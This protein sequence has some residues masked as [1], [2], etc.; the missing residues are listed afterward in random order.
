MKQAK[1]RLESEFRVLIGN[2]RS[3]AAEMVQLLTVVRVPG[4]AIQPQVLANKTNNTILVR[5]TGPVVDIDEPID[6]V[7]ADAMLRRPRSRARR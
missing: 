5:A 7:V 3:Q 1:P 4:M 2:R 6:L